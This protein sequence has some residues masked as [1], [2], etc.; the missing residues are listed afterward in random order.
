MSHSVMP[1]APPL[2]CYP[3]YRRHLSM[4]AAVAQ[5]VLL[6]L[7][8]GY[9]APTFEAKPRRP[10][11]VMR[12]P[13]LRH[14]HPSSGESRAT[15][16]MVPPMLTARPYLVYS[17]RADR[18]REHCQGHPRRCVALTIP[19]PNWHL[20]EDRAHT[21]QLSD[22]LTP[23]LRRLSSRTPVCTPA[24]PVPPRIGSPGEPLLI[25]MPQSSSP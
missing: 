3:S 22:R 15:A 12:P 24:P 6:P 2:C 1:S 23:F 11:P 19:R 8:A 7:H 13:E 21:N 10:S 4:R 18:R 17:S 25:E 20:P 5:R 14:C 9:A 16:T